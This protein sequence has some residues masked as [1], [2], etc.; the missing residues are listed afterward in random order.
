MDDRKC[1]CSMIRRNDCTA[2]FAGDLFLGT[3]GMDDDEIVVNSPHD[4]IASICGTRENNREQE[5]K[6]DA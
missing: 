2:G 5:K 4:Q 1:D 3:V 6:D